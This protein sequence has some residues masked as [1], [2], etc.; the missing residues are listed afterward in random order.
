MAQEIKYRRNADIY[1]ETE[2]VPGYEFPFA[3]GVRK[4]VEAIEDATE[5]TDVAMDNIKNALSYGIEP[6]L[7]HKGCKG[8][9]YRI[10]EGRA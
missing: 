10:Y 3:S 1:Y 4:I 2:G 5:L 6:N 7:L 8:K 9:R